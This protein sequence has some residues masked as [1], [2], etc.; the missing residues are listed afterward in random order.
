MDTHACIVS[1]TDFFR[2]GPKYGFLTRT[3]VQ[4]HFEGSST[5]PHRKHESF[6]E[7]TG[8]SIALERVL[9]TSAPDVAVGIEAGEGLDLP[10]AGGAHLA[11]LF[12]DA[13]LFAC[14]IE[15]RNPVEPRP[16]KSPDGQIKNQRDVKAF[17]TGA[18][19]KCARGRGKIHAI[20]AGTPR[21]IPRPVVA[22]ACRAGCS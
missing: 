5:E 13:D 7:R 8:V 17:P 6:E 14:H 1:R 16:R 20:R 11:P 21:R 12:A 19:V 10:G 18:L 22:K 3:F 9:P 2:A 4:D 15:G